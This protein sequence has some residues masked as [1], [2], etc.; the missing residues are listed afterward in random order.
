MYTTPILLT[1]D[2]IASVTGSPYNQGNSGDADFAMIVPGAQALAGGDTTYRLVWSGNINATDD[3]FLNGQVWTLEVYTG[4]GDPATD[5]TGWAVVPGHDALTPKHDYV[6]GVGA[7]DDYIVFEGA[8]GFLLY[9]I[10]GGLP[11][12]PTT[13]TYLAS[14]QNGDLATGDNDGNLDFVDAY[15]AYC[16]CSGTMIETARGPVAVED[17][18]VGDLVVTLDH[19]PQPLRWIGR[20]DVTLAGIIAQPDLR[21]FRLAAGALGPGLPQRDLWLS[22]QHRVLVRSRIAERMTGSPEVLVAAKHLCALPGIAQSLRFA[23]VRY[24]HL[25]LDR[26]ELVRA[27]GAWA[28]TLL[29]GRQAL[30][31]LDPAARR[32]LR[33]LFPGLSTETPAHAARAVLP[34]RIARRLAQRHA[35]NARALTASPT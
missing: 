33:Q 34:G 31:A 21:P 7:G 3:S 14:E 2:Q 30:R 22:P 26:H 35:R 17:L 8:G 32:E 27:E 12:T 29:V 13:L 16:F 19:G 9:D 1:G 15:G 6:V 18:R 10:R 25:R 11:D 23:P 4:T 28:E 24:L 20:R 5:I